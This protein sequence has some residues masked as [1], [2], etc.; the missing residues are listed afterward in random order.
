MYGN[1][2]VTYFCPIFL[3][4]LMVFVTAC[5][6]DENC[7]SADA[8]DDCPDTLCVASQNY[9]ITF[10]EVS[11]TNLAISF[12]WEETITGDKTHQLT[13]DVN[14]AGRVEEEI[15]QNTVVDIPIDINALID[16]RYEFKTVC[17]DGLELGTESFEVV[18]GEDFD[19]SCPTPTNFKLIGRTT[20]GANALFIW[21]EVEVT[22]YLLS[23]TVIEKANGVATF[24]REE[25]IDQNFFS[26]GGANGFPAE[27]HS[28][29]ELFHHEFTLYSSCNP[30]SARHRVCVDF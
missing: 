27:L 12:N 5:G 18:F 25:N 6:C 26:S 22:E 9:T 11:E 21:D 15:N 2:L 4:F 19:P 14:G 28:S 30:T 13:Y 23:Y 3:L 17:C 1:K 16:I 29:P 10:M 24:V 20:D 8:C 7:C